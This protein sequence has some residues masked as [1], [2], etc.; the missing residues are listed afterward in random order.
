LK[1][2][3]TMLTWVGVAVTVLASPAEGAFTQA[4]S[5]EVLSPTL[6]RHAPERTA[7]AVLEGWLTNLAVVRPAQGGAGTGSMLLFMTVAPVGRHGMG[8]QTVG[9]F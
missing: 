5:P 3:P 1:T 4:L 6:V 9:S 2:S 8:L 7:A